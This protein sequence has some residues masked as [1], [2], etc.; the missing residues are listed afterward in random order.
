MLRLPGR[1]PTDH[2]DLASDIRW[3]DSRELG[4]LVVPQ[5]DDFLKG[6]F[7]QRSRPAVDLV[8]GILRERELE[9]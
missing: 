3:L 5:V 7:D 4:R 1:R 2:H 9:A 8:A 6:R